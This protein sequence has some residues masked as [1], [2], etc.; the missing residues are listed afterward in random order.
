MTAL[1]G[2]SRR[3]IARVAP[4]VACAGLVLV[5]AG[6]QVTG[7][8][9]G[10]AV[11]GADASL[12]DPLL[13]PPPAENAAGKAA[14]DDVADGATVDAS[15]GYDA[16]AEL[17]RIRA[18][19]D[20]WGAKLTAE[21]ANI[22]AAVQLAQSD[23]A[24][25]RMTGDVAD[26]VRGEAATDRALKVQPDYAPAQAMR[27]AILISLHRFTQAADVANGVLVAAPDDPTALG[28]LGD[29][30]LETGDL[31]GARAAYGSLTATA[32]GSASRVREGRLA[33][34]TGDTVGAIAAVRSAVTAAL[35]EALEGDALAFYDSTLG[36]LLV[37]TGDED[38]GRRAYEAGLAVRPDHPASLVGLARLDAFDGD[39]DA[40][41]AKLDTA[42]DAIP[43]PEWL[44]RRQDLL[45]LRGKAGDAALAS[46]D[47]ATIDAIARLAGPAG[48]VYD[49]IRSLY[50]S[51]HGL[52]PDLAVKLATDELAIRKDVYGYD[53]L[54]WALVNAGRPADAV[55]PIETAL[56]V[57]T[58]DA[59]IWYHAGVIEA[60]TGDAA[61][62]RDHLTKA[63]ALGAALDP[64]ARD[65]AASVLA[66]V[67]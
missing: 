19:V 38:G 7:L 43:Q 8:V 37:A 67:P 36:D 5:L 12:N 45:T 23:V 35:D 24:L 2:P 27:A 31:A 32:D 22:V 46:T 51:D 61:A 25:G 63:L 4:L 57:G 26:Y 9:G 50:L 13:V 48:S 55:A 62:A 65:R 41:I 28:A 66:T 47:G 18:D 59:R 33:F 40:A 54:A 44:G 29:A 42:I 52:Q 39:L 30:R 14:P 20:F 10:H 11:P 58:P 17:A 16:A 6:A 60:A 21:P 1:P 3:P 53:A 34:I 56:A 64:V 49:R 15:D